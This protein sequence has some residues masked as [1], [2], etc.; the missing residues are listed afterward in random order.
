MCVHM[1]AHETT[2]TVRVN[3]SQVKFTNKD[4][5]IELR[6]LEL[7][8]LSKNGSDPCSFSSSYLH[9]WMTLKINVSME[10]KRG[11]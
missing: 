9:D 3:L 1:K 8:V 2:C 11:Q 10:I 7:R 5:T 6:P 4:K